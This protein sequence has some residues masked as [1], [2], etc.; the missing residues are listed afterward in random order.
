M[1]GFALADFGRNLGGDALVIANYQDTRSVSWLGFIT[2]VAVAPK[3]VLTPFAGVLVDRFD[4]RRVM[5]ICNAALV[6]R[7]A[8]LLAAVLASAYR[9]QLVP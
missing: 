7:S 4:R 9:V 5:R 1:S 3:I 8:G 6:L 2:F